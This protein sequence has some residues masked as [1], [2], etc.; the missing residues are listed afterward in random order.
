[1][2]TAE[3]AVQVLYDTLATSEYKL[4]CTY[5]N[6]AYAQDPML[7]TPVNQFVLDRT[8]NVA[9][10]QLGPAAQVKRD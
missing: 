8:F 5:T 6:T 9:S 1:M 4:T 2:I 3:A 7:K 10:T